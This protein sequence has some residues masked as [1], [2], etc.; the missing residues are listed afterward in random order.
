MFMRLEKFEDPIV[1]DLTDGDEVWDR[2]IMF[3]PD[4]VP[5]FKQIPKAKEFINFTSDY[6]RDKLIRCIP[7]TE[8]EEFKGDV[9]L[10]GNFPTPD[11]EIRFDIGKQLNCVGRV[12]PY[13]RDEIFQQLSENK[14]TNTKTLIVGE[15]HIKTDGVA[16]DYMNNP[17]EVHAPIILYGKS[18]TI[19]W[20]ASPMYVTPKAFADVAMHIS[21]ME[22]NEN[23]VY[24]VL[25]Q[26]VS[27]WVSTLKIAVIDTIMN[28]TAIQ[29]MLLNP[30]I[31][32]RCKRETV[33]YENTLRE[34]NPKPKKKQPKKYIKRLIV[35]DISDLEFGNEK[36][37]HEIKEP[38]WWVTGHYRTY[39]KTGKTIFIE[40]YWKGPFR[41]YGFTSEPRERAIEFGSEIDQFFRLVQSTIPDEE[42]DKRCSANT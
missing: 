2:A 12:V 37:K 39:K 24:G 1:I 35:G 9:F 38:F 14:N 29:I 8:N 27:T 33:P 20:S 5:D 26:Q 41:D 30:V 11:I 25:K 21:N 18:L 4:S 23:P 3:H 22:N 42:S 31:S 36:R 34:R 28:W 19:E 15:V 13:S 6:D 10:S 17:L 16:L 40:G 7:L 32:F